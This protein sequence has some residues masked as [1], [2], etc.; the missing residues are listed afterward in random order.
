[1]EENI[2]NNPQFSQTEADETIDLKAYFALFIS[3]WPW[4]VAS[5][6]I[7]LI[8]A[9]FYLLSTP[10]LSSTSGYNLYSAS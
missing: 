8:A 9:K 1:M 6:L 2:Q 10:K 5:V 4:F 7:A 3:R